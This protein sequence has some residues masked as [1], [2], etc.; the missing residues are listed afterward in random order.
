IDFHF[1]ELRAEA[2]ET[3]LVVFL[4]LKHAVAF[5]RIHSLGLQCFCKCLRPVRVRAKI[6]KLLLQIRRC[7]R[8]AGAHRRSC[9]RSAGDGAEWQIGIAQLE[10]YFLDWN[11]DGIGADLRE[12][13]PLPGAQLMGRTSSDGRAIR[14]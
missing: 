3:E 1:T 13:R 5:D 14:A 6:N 10:L 2:L 12:R 11:T 7:Q 8:D 9:L 4:E